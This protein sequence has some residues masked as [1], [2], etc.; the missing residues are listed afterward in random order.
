MTTT[1]AMARYHHFGGYLWLE[2]GRPKVDPSA[3]AD[4]TA[5]AA[6][7]VL[8]AHRDRVQAMLADAEAF[9]ATRC[10]RS[11]KVWTEADR[12]HDA[13]RAWGGRMDRA[14][15]LVALQADRRCYVGPAGLLVGIGLLVDWPP[16]DGG[17]LRRRGG[18]RHA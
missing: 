15:L 13:Y 7:E 2:D 9:T 11:A 1:E 14:T 17:T 18:R 8:R 16:L 10:S 6:L 3:P 12:L 5:A 4:P